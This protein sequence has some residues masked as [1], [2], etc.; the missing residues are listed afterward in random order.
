VHLS[1]GG[2]ELDLV[3][4]DYTLPT[5]GFYSDATR[6]PFMDSGAGLWFTSPGRGDNTITGYFNVLQADYDTSGNIVSFAA[7]FKQYDECV[8]ANWVSG[9]FRYNSD[10]PIPEPATLLLLGLG[11]AMFRKMK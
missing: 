6:W 1:A 4:P 9:S 10:V 5:V 3:G 8:T 11:A 7:D 2:Y